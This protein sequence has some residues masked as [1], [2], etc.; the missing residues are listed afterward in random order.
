MY[1]KIAKGSYKKGQ[2]NFS[3]GL[4]IR[5]GCSIL[6]LYIIKK[7]KKNTLLYYC[8]YL[9]IFFLGRFVIL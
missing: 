9:L 2:K 6:F 5:N 7:D 4:I 1:L 3:K 8:L